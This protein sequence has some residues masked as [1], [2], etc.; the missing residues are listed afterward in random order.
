MKGGKLGGEADASPYKR[1]SFSSRSLA[2]RFAFGEEELEFVVPW[3]G[4]RFEAFIFRFRCCPA[5]TA[6][7][8]G[9]EPA[10]WHVG[11][12]SRWCHSVD[13]DQELKD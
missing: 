1:A 8:F 9:G 11:K 3:S 2:Q 6:A 7:Y 12:H 4:R 13:A 10:D 5:F